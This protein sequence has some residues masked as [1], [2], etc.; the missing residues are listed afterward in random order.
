MRTG[1]DGS[2]PKVAAMPCKAWKFSNLWVFRWR[3]WNFQTER[4]HKP[5][6]Q[7]QL[8]SSTIF[9]GADLEHR[10]ASLSAGTSLVPV[11]ST[12][13]NWIRGRQGLPCRAGGEGHPSPKRRRRGQGP[14]APGAGR[15]TAPGE[16][17]V[18]HPKMPY[19][20]VNWSQG[21]SGMQPCLFGV[22]PEISG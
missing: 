7:L 11:R 8:E 1:C 3:R 6:L 12:S 19:P 10:F 13:P 17:R 21:S 22:Q 16:V 9:W 20:G 18:F 14:R 4:S 15:P 5:Q 2:G